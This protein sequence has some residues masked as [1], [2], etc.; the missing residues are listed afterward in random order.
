M[1]FIKMDVTYVY[2]WQLAEELLPVIYLLITNIA[3]IK[4]YYKLL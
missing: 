3:L 1:F 4:V 2:Q